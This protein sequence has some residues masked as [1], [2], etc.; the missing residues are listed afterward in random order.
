MDGELNLSVECRR[1]Q[2]MLA[3]RLFRMNGIHMLVYGV[4]PTFGA[5]AEKRIIIYLFYL[6]HFNDHNYLQSLSPSVEPID[7]SFL[8]SN[9]QSCKSRFQ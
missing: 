3:R 9:H 2:A 5:K 1:Y 4:L 7:H 6:V 8:V